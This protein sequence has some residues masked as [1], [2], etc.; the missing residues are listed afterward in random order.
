MPQYRTAVQW[1][2]GG[3]RVTGTWATEGPARTRWTEWVGLYGV[4]GSTVTVVLAKVLPDGTERV[5]KAWPPP[6]EGGGGSK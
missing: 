6:A 5:L 3:P 4:P 2:P 1:R